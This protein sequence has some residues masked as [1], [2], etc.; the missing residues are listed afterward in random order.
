MNFDAT[1]ATSVTA[2]TATIPPLSPGDYVAIVLE[3]DQ[4][5]VTGSPASG[6]AT[7]QIDLCLTGGQSGVVIEDLDGNPV[8]CTG[9]NTLG[10]DSYQVLIIANPANASGNTTTQNLE[11][12]VG[13]A[14]GTHAPGRLILSVADDGLG[15]S[16]TQFA[17]N[18]GTIQ[19]HQAAASAATVGAAFYFTT[20]ACGTSPAQLEAFSST[21][22][23]P[24]LFD[25]SGTR[26]A[27]PLVRQ[28]PDFA[29]P[30]GVNDTFLGFTLASDWLSLEGSSTPP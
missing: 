6:G 8:S 22:G 2:L 7:S 17:T 4:P 26:L 15:S 10:Q 16:I 1:G 12:S 28:K 5:F 30:D 27:T 18:G 20:P 11:F 14:N 21:G 23:T 29:A 9:P 3:W 13:L 19:G 25:T 24:V